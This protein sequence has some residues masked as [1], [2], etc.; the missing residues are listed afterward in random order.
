MGGLDP[1]MLRR[2]GAAAFVGA[3]D[4]FSASLAHVYEPARRTLAAY[5]GSLLRLRRASDDAESDFGYVANGDLDVAAITA[6][7]GG[8]SYVVTVYDQTTNADCVTQADKTKQPLFVASAQNGHAGMSFDGSNDYLTGTFTTGGALSQPF[9]YF[10]VE[11]LSAADMNNNLAF[12]YSGTTV[13][14]CVLYKGAT[15]YYYAGVDVNSSVARAVTPRIWSALFNGAA[16]ALYMNGGLVANG[17]PG[18]ANPVGLTVGAE[19]TSAS[20][21]YEGQVNS[22]I[23]CDPVLGDADRILMQTAINGYWGVY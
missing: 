5:T 19:Y 16:S 12:V 4:A 9:N 3:Y 1:L 23:I 21:F 20:Y 11:S 17:N 13:V 7:A 10:T 15:Y 6:W 2:G 8:N 22:H 14:R 18:T